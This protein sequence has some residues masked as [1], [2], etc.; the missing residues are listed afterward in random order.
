MLIKQKNW[1]N[2]KSLK[3]PVKIQKKNQKR[4]SSFATLL[5]KATGTEIAASAMAHCPRSHTVSESYD[6]SNQCLDFFGMFTGEN[7]VNNIQSG[8]EISVYVARVKV[9]CLTSEE[10]LA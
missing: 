10:L 6:D 3:I 9:P 1:P 5:K 8:R 4:I 7:T 2:Y